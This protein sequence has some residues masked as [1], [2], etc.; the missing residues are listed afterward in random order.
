MGDK[1][2]TEGAVLWLERIQAAVYEELFSAA[3][4]HDIEGFDKWVGLLERLG[5]V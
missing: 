4:A 1:T 5:L 2:G 3:V